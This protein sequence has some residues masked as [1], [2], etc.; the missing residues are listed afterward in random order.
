M[1]ARG[2]LLI[3]FCLNLAAAL[4]W[5][6]HPPARAVPPPAT[7]PGIPG[8]TLLAEAE[9]ADLP[10]DAELA[11]AP[12]RME[13]TPVCLSVGPFD[14]PS[15]LRRAVDALGGSVGKLQYREAQVQS[16]RG[17]RVFI[18]AAPSRGEA[19][20]TARSLAA[21]GVRDYY[22]VT[23]GPGENT[24]SLGLFREQ[25]NAEARLAEV[26]ALGI[27]AVMEAASEERPQ[28]WLE[29]AVAPDFDWRRPL[30][31]GAWQA[32]PIPCF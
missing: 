11:V 1:L 28:W 3:L 22:V 7:E 23:A 10:A 15:A 18:P 4:W 14:T 8:L 30:G 2:A 12:T 13:A 16:T 24:V 32:R 6:L 5:G 9:L 20:A 17:W 27:E 25:R 29:I 19:L 31:S 26:R 21:Q